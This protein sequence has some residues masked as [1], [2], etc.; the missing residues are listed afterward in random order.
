MSAKQT[1]DKAKA[2]EAKAADKASEAE[3]AAAAAD[4]SAEGAAAAASENAP[5]TSAPT[6]K[7][8]AYEALQRIRHNGKTIL[9]GR[10]LE[11]TEDEAAPLLRLN[12]VRGIVK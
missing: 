9:P 5:E 3:T 1:S 4:T 10:S 11:L 6:A 12:A 2:A 7:A 8:S